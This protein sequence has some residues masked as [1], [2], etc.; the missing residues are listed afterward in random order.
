M[1]IETL[2]HRRF[3]QWARRQPDAPAVVDGATTLTYAQ[4]DALA[5]TLAAR[6]ADDGVGIEDPVAVQMPRGYR[7]IVSFLAVLKAGGCYIPVD[8]EYPSARQSFMKEDCGA[9][10]TLTELDVD[11]AAAAPLRAAPRRDL[12]GADLAY[13]VYT[14]GSTGRPKGVMVEHRN[15]CALMDE[16][17]LGVGPGE[18]VAQTVSISF[19]VA[20]FEIWGALCHGGCLVIMS[21]GRSVKELAAEIRAVR[22]DWMF[23]TAGVFHLMVEHDPAALS[24]VGVLQAG[25]DVLG[26]DQFCRAATQPRRGLFNAYGPSETTVYSG[27]YQAVPGQRLESVPIGTPPRGERMVIADDGQDDGVGEILIG[28]AGV[29]RG[30]YRRPRLTAERFVP[31]PDATTPGG[32]RYRTGDLGSVAA[33]GAFL[34]H[35]RVDR[36]VKIRGFRIELPEIE[37]MLVAHPDVGQAAVKVF[38]VGTEKRLG[39]FV[40]PASD[41]PVSAPH[42]MRWLRERLPT[43]M[44]PSYVRVLDDIPLDP[45]GK[46]DRAALPYPWASR[47]DL[48]GLDGYEEPISPLE[49]QLSLVWADNLQIDQVG[50]HDNYFLLGGDSLRVISL[51]ADLGEV[52]IE[53]TAEEFLG[54]Q[55]VADLA[56]LVERRQAAAAEGGRP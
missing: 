43:Y 1:E 41:S 34:I 8:P 13:I 2:V 16:P 54:H 47:A 11:A 7:V 5:S 52:G 51:L 46:V 55:T 3:E 45:N 31:D 12:I 50:R 6:L 39:A 44:L 49:K 15:V 42:L 25:G 36:Q 29:S 48:D 53:V 30:Y 38:D 14:S 17:R 28:G 27:I 33:D 32:R 9:V 21:S 56:E 18:R 24:A 40:A 10:L 37:N 19:D 35:G 4:L 26:P 23:L 22:P 20:A